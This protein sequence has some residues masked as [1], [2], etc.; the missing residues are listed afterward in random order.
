MKKKFDIKDLLPSLNSMVKLIAQRV[1]SIP[2]VS[3]LGFKIT[4]E[5]WVN[6]NGIGLGAISCLREP[7][8]EAI[9]LTIDIQRKERQILCWMGIYWSDGR[10]VQDIDELIIP[11]E[12]Y[13]ETKTSFKNFL[14]K[15]YPKAIVLLSSYLIKNKKEDTDEENNL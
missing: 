1:E 15:N 3:T 4:S 10:V 7:S 13:A 5:A 6:D 8:E 12:N 9:E 14:Q 11:E 2:D